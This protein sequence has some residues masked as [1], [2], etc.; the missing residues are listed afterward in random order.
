MYNENLQKIVQLQE[1]KEGFKLLVTAKDSR[2]KELQSNIQR[3]KEI[4]SAKVAAVQAALTKK[5][6]SILSYSKLSDQNGSTV[7]DKNHYIQKL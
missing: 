2:I 5:E 1:E 7:E 6:A 4:C 3:E